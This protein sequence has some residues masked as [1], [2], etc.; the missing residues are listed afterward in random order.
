[1]DFSVLCMGE[2]WLVAAGKPNKVLALPFVSGDSV[3][4]QEVDEILGVY[5][6]GKFSINLSEHFL[7]VDLS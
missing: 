1:M 4:S 6:I 3:H 7:L 2:V 5:F